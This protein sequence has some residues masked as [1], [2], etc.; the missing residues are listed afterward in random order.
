MKYL[1]LC[2]FL[3]GCGIAQLDPRGSQVMIVDSM[4]AQDSFYFEPLGEVRCIGMITEEDCRRDLR[5]Q[6]GALGADIV[7][8]T[9]SDRD[10]CGVDFLTPSAPKKCTAMSGEAF[11]KIPKPTAAAAYCPPLAPGR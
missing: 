3:T 8:V 11:R 7:R 4:G 6:A 9:S 10:F 2:F 5:N 1:P